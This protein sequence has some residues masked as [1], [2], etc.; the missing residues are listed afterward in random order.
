VSLA[1]CRSWS[2]SRTRPVPSGEGSPTGRVFHEAGIQRD[3]NH[4]GQH[5]GGSRKNGSGNEKGGGGSEGWHGT[6]SAG[7][8]PNGV[9]R[10]GPALSFGGVRFGDEPPGERGRS[11]GSRS[12]SIRSQHDQAGPAPRSAL[13]RRLAAADHCALGPEPP[14]AARDRP[15]VSGPVTG[16][17]GRAANRSAGPAHPRGR[18]GTA[19]ADAAAIAAARP[20]HARRVLSP[21]AVAAADERG[22]PGADRPDQAAAAHGP[23]PPAASPRRNRRSRATLSKA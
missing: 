15:Q 13:L 7:R 10:T 14:A 16:R 21:L 9:R 22:V 18:T 6:S 5:L 20:G 4:D 3:R 11:R 23:A 8:R 1:R 2:E 17:R 19:A 12:G